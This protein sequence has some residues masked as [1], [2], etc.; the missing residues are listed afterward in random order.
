MEHVSRFEL[1]N[2]HLHC[3]NQHPG[4]QSASSPRQTTLIQLHLEVL[5]VDFLTIAA[6]DIFIIRALVKL[7]HFLEKMM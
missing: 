7:D 3:P 1:L 5:R 4:Q 2:Y 6:A